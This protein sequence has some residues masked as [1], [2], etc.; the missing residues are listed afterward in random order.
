MSTEREY[1][2]TLHNAGDATDFI[3]QMT[4][5]SSVGDIP[6]RSVTVVNERP[7]SSRNTHYALTDAEAEQLRNDPRV[8]AVE[9]VARRKRI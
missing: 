5:S 3:E 8:L 2:V 1:I 6:V 9:N 7:F 4:G